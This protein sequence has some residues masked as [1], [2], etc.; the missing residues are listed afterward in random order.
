M[1]VDSEGDFSKRSLRETFLGAIAVDIA[2][3]LIKNGESY[4]LSVK[5]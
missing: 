2:N 5:I 4:S 3:C 1:F